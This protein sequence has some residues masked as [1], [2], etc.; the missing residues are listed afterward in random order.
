MRKL[1]TVI[2]VLTVVGAGSARAATTPPRNTAPPSISG[3]A[4]QGETLTASPGTWSGTQPIT[5]GYQWRRCNAK[6]LSCANIIGATNKT[7]RLTSVDVGNTIR[8]RVRAANSTGAANATSAPTAVVTTS[9]S[10]TLDTNRASVVYGRAFELNGQVANGQAGESVTITE[11]QMPAVGGVQ[12]H[13][14]ATVQ[15]G[16]NG[17]VCLPAPPA[18]PPPST[19][20]ARTAATNHPSRDRPPPPPPH[21]G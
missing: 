17:S 9:K 14:L 2:A 1:L 11:R 15:T 18:H 10:I 12:P 7:L 13:S 21:G 20:T 8:V 5:F 4:Q 3:T 16:A 6:G 19:A